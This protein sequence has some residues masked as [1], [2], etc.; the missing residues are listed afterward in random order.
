M[1]SV[2]AFYSRNE[3][4]TPGINVTYIRTGGRFIRPQ[5]KFQE[6]QHMINTL[7]IGD[8]AKA[9]GVTEKQL[10][11]WEHRG[12]I[13]GIDRVVCGERAF[14]VYNKEQIQQIKTIKGFL[15]KGF[16]LPVAAEK[17]LQNSKKEDETIENKR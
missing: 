13:Q 4:S 7:T 3:N 12:Y 2:G 10:R 15:D 17:A 6:D 16:T 5:I 11:N 8:T 1:I 9:T 14:R